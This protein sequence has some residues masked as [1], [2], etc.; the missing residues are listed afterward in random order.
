[1]VQYIEAPATV[2][3]TVN[4]VAGYPAPNVSIVLYANGTQIGSKSMSIP[5][6]QSDSLAVQITGLGSYTIAAHATAS[7]QFGTVEGDSVPIDIV[8]GE[9]PSIVWG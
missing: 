4:M 6:G 2:T 5:K 3:V 8:V 9:K 7:N 1:M